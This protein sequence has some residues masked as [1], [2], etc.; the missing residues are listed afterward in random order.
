M[1]GTIR[2]HQQ[3]VWIV[4][5]TITILSF[6]IFFSPNV[7]LTGARRANQASREFG[8]IDGQ[9]IKADEYYTGLK[10]ARLNHFFRSGKWA[11]ND[12]NSAEALK[13]DAV[14]RVFLARKLKDFDIK[15]SDD[16]V[17]RLTRERLGKDLADNVGRFVAEYMQPQGMNMQDLEHYLHRETGIQQLVNVAAASAKLMNPREAE[18]LYKSENEAMVTQVALFWGSNYLDK[19]SVT[20]DAAQ[21]FYTNNMSRYRLPDRIQVAYVQFPFTNF[22][23]EADKQLAQNTNINAAIEKMYFEKGPDT[24]KDEKGQKLSETDAKAKIKEDARREFALR[25]AHI[26]ANEFGTA[27]Y[28]DNIAL[29]DGFEKLATAKALEVK[30]TPPFDRTKGLEDTDFPIAFRQKAFD[31]TDQQTVSVQPIIGSNAVYVI[32]LKTKIPSQLQTFDQVKDKVTTDFKYDKALQMARQDGQ[33]FAQTATNLLTQNKSFE[34]AAKAANGE[35][36]PLP[37]FSASTSSLTNIDSRIDFRA[38]HS[39]AADLKKGQVSAAVSPSSNRT[40]ADG[41]MVV[42]MKDRIP[43]SDEKM[44]QNLPEFL[45]RIRLYRQNEAFNQWFR[46]EAEQA[47]LQVPQKESLNVPRPQA[48]AN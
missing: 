8:L 17:A 46:K 12:E 7:D 32:A 24:F 6:V 9:P 30:V 35:V 13:R 39:T 43:V 1:F 31:L 23:D 15:V 14:Y 38:L 3:W 25:Q 41:I 29:E 18:F 36:I 42:Y 4:I 44:K 5:I 21:Q 20:N 34:E 10:E 28:N 45:A 11:D 37:E 2:R 16:A 26:K 27:L 19:V 48:K 33:K 40:L 22:L 47:R